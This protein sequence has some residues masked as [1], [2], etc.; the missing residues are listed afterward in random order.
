MDPTQKQLVSRNGAPIAVYDWPYIQHQPAR[1]AVLIVHTLGDYGLRY[2]QLADRL[3]HWGFRVRTF[4]FY[5]HG[6]SGGAKG[7][8]I[9]GNQL[10]EDLADVAHD[11]QSQLPAGTPLITMGY[12]MGA[13]VAAQAQLQGL[14]HADAHCMISPMLRLR[15]TVVQRTAM[16]IF[17]HLLPDRVGPAHFTPLMHT[18]DPDEQLIMRNDPQWVRV[19]TVRLGDAMFNMAAEVQRRHR[20]WQSPSLIVYNAKSP[21][22]GSVM[23]CGTEDFFLRATQAQI[24]SKRF[25]NAYPDLLHDGIKE[26]VYTRMQQWLDRHF[27]AA[28][29]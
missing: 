17:R 14:L 12:S 19:M 5:G 4:D 23:V 22:K 7:C 1:A 3:S 11:W 8:L 2:Q 27:P 20:E 6:Q 25:E 16:A 29:Q 26:Q 18:S 28:R 10:A 13:T 21:P 24:E 15:M 9:H